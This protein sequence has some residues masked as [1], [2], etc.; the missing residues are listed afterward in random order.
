M[1]YAVLLAI[2][3][4]EKN[5]GPGVQAEKIM[6]VLCSRC[7]RNLKS[8]TQ[9]DTCGLLVHNSCGNVKEQ[10]ADSRKWICD[11]CRSDRLRLLEEKL[12]KVLLQI[13]DLTRKNKALEEHLRLAA[14]GREAGKQ[15]TVL[16]HLKGGE[17][18]VLGDLIM[19]NVGTECSDMKIECL[20]GIRMEKMHR[21]I[22]DRDL[23]SPD[24]VVIH[25]GTNDL[26]RNRNL[27][28]FM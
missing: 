25:V 20:Q 8:G 7:E 19:Q 2:G 26:R 28:Y 3:G 4:V 1:T 24:T 27:D 6:Q 14:A 13:D 21:V 23:G 5:P 17:C 16:G 18:L 12:Q 15:N 11:K 22:E 9:C 10:V